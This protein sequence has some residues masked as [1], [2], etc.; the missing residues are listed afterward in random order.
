MNIS[1]DSQTASSMDHFYSKSTED[2]RHLEGDFVNDNENAISIAYSLEID[3][4]LCFELIIIIYSNNNKNLPN[5]KKTK[6]I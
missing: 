5:K 4:E 6:N 3:T 2:E 1:C